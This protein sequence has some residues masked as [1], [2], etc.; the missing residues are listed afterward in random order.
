MTRKRQSQQFT[1]RKEKNIKRCLC[2]PLVPTLFI[3]EQTAGKGVVISSFDSLPE[4]T[5]K[6]LHV[7]SLIETYKYATL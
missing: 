7:K 1:K 3:G 2:L 6:Y 4:K 5:T